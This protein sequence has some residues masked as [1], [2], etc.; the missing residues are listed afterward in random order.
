M[1]RILFLILALLP[2][3]V[4][5]QGPIVAVGGGDTGPE[6]VGRVLELA[7][8]R[9]AIVAVLPQS[10]AEPDAGDASVQM[11]LEAGAKEAAKVSF[12]DRAAARAFLERA[13]LIW[14]PGGD[15]NRFMAAIAGT[16][17]DEVIHVRHRAGVA[18]G[19]TSAGAAILAAEMFTGDAD[20]T[21]LT[22]GATVTAR[23]LGLLPGLL[24]DQHFLTRQRD[25]RLISAVFDHPS[26]V[27]VG[28]DE[29][30]AIVVRGD[31]FDVI[32]K[33]SIVVVDARRASIDKA[34]PKQLVSGTGVTLAVLRAGQSYS[35]RAGR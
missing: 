7:G 23:G 32:G 35:L 4:L 30:T 21:S 11:W 31:R 9:R 28:I 8:G 14:M 24:I 18:V 1:R 25:N 34:A 33:S 26:L 29:S 17:L 12:G 16:G 6:I 5:A 10:S 3:P 13:T 22:A 27:G 2:A 15:Q 20:L 19:G